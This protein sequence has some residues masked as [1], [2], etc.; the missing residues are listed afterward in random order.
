MQLVA[1][2]KYQKAV[3]VLKSQDE[4]FLILEQIVCD[5]FSEIDSKTLARMF[6]KDKRKFKR[7]LF[8]LITSDLGFCGAF[9]YNVVRNLL[10][11]FNSDLDKVAVFGKKGLFILAK[12][13]IS[14]VLEFENSN[15]IKESI[16]M[17]IPNLSIYYEFLH[18]D[19]RELI[20][21][22]NK[23]ISPIKIE[24]VRHSV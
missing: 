23:Y 5:I 22:Y 10:A 12:H 7:R 11:D 17:I 3:K 19:Y 1:S 18:N 2:V 13:E 4:Y 20:I 9:N 15:F 24:T 6:H 8:I 14:P 16:D 21:I